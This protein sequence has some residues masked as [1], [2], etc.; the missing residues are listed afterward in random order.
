MEDLLSKI[1][2]LEIE[3]KTVLKNHP[4]IE[5]FVRTQLQKAIKSLSKATGRIE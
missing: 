4:E 5:V 3:A 1:E 2:E